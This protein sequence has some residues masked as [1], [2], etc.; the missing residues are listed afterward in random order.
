MKGSARFVLR[1]ARREARASWRRFAVLILAVAIGVGALVAINSF[2]ENMQGSVRGRAR[3]LLGADLAVRSGR[4]FPARTERLLDS[5][6]ARPGVRRARVTFLGAMAYVPRSD[7]A[8]TVTVTA[9]EGGYPF[10]GDIETEPAGQWP[11]I[12]AGER[13]VLVDPSL[14]TALDARVGDT[15]ALGEGRFAIAG[16]LRNFPGDVGLGSAFSPRV[17]IAARHLE[18]TG[19]LT[20]GSR[21]QRGAFF[22]LPPGTAAGG[23]ADRLRT[24]L[25][26]DRVNLRTAEEDQE[27]L[28]EALTRMAGYLGLV[29]LVALLLG[30]L[31]VASAVH[32]FVRQKEETIAVLRCL[33]ATTGEVFAVYLLQA[34][35][36]G[37]GGSLLGVALGVLVQ[38][39]LPQLVAG[40]VPVDVEVALSWRSV[41]MG[42]GT[43]LWVA[44][45]FSLLPLLA[46]RRIA[47]L[48]ALRRAYEPAEP[49]AGGGARRR[50]RDWWRVAAMVLVAASVVALAALQAGR[51]TTGLGFAA[52]I[53]V[54][55]GVLAL[56]AWLL[57]RA[58]RRW[59]PARWPYVWRQGLANLYRPAN[60]TVAVILALGFGAFLLATLLVAQRTL[61]DTLE[62]RGGALRPNLVLV[63]VQTDQ[64]AAAD[65]VL[66]AEELPVTGPVP[67]VPMRI[68]SIRGRPVT[69]IL[70]DTAAGRE[71]E[72][73]RPPGWTLRR[74]YRST[75]RDSVMASE[76]IVAGEWF[77]GPNAR[78][79]RERA[80]RGARGARGAAAGPAVA[81]VSIE[82]GLAADLG[83]EVGDEIVWDVQG[84]RIPSRVTSIREVDWARFEP[85]FF[86]V[87]QPGTLADAPQT[88]VYLTRVGDAAA[89][90]RLQRRLAER[91]PNVT[92][93]DLAL[94]QE[95]LERVVSRVVLAIRFM[96][97][98][99]LATGGLVLFGAVAT[100][101]FQRVREAVLLKTLGATRSQVARV[102]LAEYLAL[103][104]LAALTALGLAVGAGWALARF[105]FD[106]ALAVPVV[107][108]A[109]LAAGVVTLTVVVGVGNSLDVLR[110]PPLEVLREA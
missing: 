24:P 37:L 2:T 99:S 69:A 39:A 7:G 106:V 56:V 1:L 100:S 8:R 74:E 79:V 49:A 84:V 88:A 63:D 101:R 45:V 15:L 43:G 67:I 90:G 36:M 64:R 47:P 44:L 14:L 92:T 68:Q 110:R 4:A 50:P 86:F 32:V 35:A 19:I 54:A 17:A 13:V 30:G 40:F 95:V 65:S 9:V 5:L 109:A 29:A 21:A 72:E 62:L 81:E 31:G 46:T 10:Y 85:N 71:G 60:Q 104:L 89:R 28:G 38:Q 23:V 61:L 48:A 77:E 57:V 105:M 107:E 12:A 103:G 83:V 27:N 70:A 97:F 93:L 80:A 42:V 78:A 51:W 41:A 76:K 26:A 53:G 11:R 59:F 33:G 102:L 25:R 22:A 18:E 98:F 58:V 73:G 82:L 87:F 108:L 96:A 94:V 16:A 3:A 6:A 55:L 75:Y 52:G 91:F 34:A 66:R 20:F